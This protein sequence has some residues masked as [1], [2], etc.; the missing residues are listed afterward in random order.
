M[1]CRMKGGMGW[2]LK[3]CQVLIFFISPLSLS[4]YSSLPDWIPSTASALSKMGKPMLK[5]LR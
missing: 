5:A 2:A 4:T 3:V 1:S